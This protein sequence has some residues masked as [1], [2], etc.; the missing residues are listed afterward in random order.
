VYRSRGISHVQAGPDI[1]GYKKKKK[2][3]KKTLQEG[4]GAFSFSFHLN[5]LPII[6]ILKLN[7]LRVIY[8][9]YDSFCSVQMLIYVSLKVEF[10][11][12]TVSL[13]HSNLT[14]SCHS[15]SSLLLLFVWLIL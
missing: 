3:I 15:S 11:N 8:E 7:K 1:Q 9:R 14:F 5:L 10:S 13:R 4:I 12:M 2:K 6:K